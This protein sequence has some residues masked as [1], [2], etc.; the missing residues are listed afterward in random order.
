MLAMAD[1]A[2]RNNLNTMLLTIVLGVLGYT[3]Y[4]SVSTQIQV[5]GFPRR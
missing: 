3:C 4:S 2:P 1:G 5:A